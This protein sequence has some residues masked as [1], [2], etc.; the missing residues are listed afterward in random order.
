[1][2]TFGFNISS[3]TQNLLGNCYRAIAAESVNI[4]RLSIFPLR[5]VLL[6]AASICQKIQRVAFIFRRSVFWWATR[7]DHDSVHIHSDRSRKRAC[8]YL[9]KASKSHTQTMRD[10]T[11]PNLYAGMNFTHNK[12]ANSFMKLWLFAY[13]FKPERTA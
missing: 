10:Q 13:Y 3:P 11:H 9:E 12:T 5:A 6:S 1:M 2:R 8:A 7:K 4:G